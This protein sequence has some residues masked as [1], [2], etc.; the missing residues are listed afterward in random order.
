M[1]LN[2]TSSNLAENEQ[3]ILNAGRIPYESFKVRDFPPPLP[4]G[5][6]GSLWLKSVSLSFF[7]G[8]G[9]RKFDF[10]RTQSLQCLA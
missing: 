10:Y 8:G 3:K 9:R 4:P 5:Y 2:Q 6:L 1:A 7:L